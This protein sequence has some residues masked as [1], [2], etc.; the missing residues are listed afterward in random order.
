MLQMDENPTDL[1]V[2]P[3]FTPTGTPHFDANAKGAIIGLQLTTKRSEIL[4]A[5]LEG[6]ALE[7]KLNLDIME[8]SG[9]KI[10]KLYATG[11]GARSKIWTQ[12]KAN[13]LNKPI[14]VIEVEEAGCFGAA[15]LA[16][17]AI[18][19]KPVSEL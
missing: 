16:C 5:L 10:N 1:L 18:T 4:K 17:S 9:M 13:I 6:V 19:K 8:R 14:T 12:I 15:M 2:L 3:H 11:C 7:M